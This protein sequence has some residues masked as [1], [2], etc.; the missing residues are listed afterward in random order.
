MRCMKSI[1]LVHLTD[2]NEPIRLGVHPNEM[3]GNP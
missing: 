1:L 2:K 3:S